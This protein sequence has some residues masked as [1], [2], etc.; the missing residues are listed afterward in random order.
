MVQLEKSRQLMGGPLDRT[1]RLLMRWIM[2]FAALLISGACSRAVTPA[3]LDTQAMPDTIPCT[4][5]VIINAGSSRRGIAAE[6]RWLAKHYPGHSRYNQS[7]ETGPDGRVYDVLSFRRREGR[8]ASVC[9]DI[10]SF[11]GQP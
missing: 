4:Q 9:F 7:L 1:L 3:G 6:R 10:T 11:N 8:D 2:T 5:A